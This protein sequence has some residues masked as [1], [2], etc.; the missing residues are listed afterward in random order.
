MPRFENARDIA[1]TPPGIQTPEIIAPA[2]GTTRG[3]PAGVAVERRSVS[4]MTAVCSGLK[5]RSSRNTKMDLPRM[6]AFR[7]LHSSEV[8]QG[9][10]TQ[11]AIHL[12]ASALLQDCAVD[13]RHQSLA[14][15]RW[16]AIPLRTELLL[17]AGVVMRWAQGVLC[18]PQDP[19]AR[20]I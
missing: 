11:R 19:A 1:Q 3:G 10:A 16:C 9:Q 12:L 8:G 6:E 7:V 13:N 5:N 2:G 17:H 4:L 15:Y 14:L 20:G 18:W